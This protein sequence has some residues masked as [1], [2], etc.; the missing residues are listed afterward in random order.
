MLRW[1]TMDDLPKNRSKNRARLDRH[2][3]AEAKRGRRRREYSLTNKE[4][5]VVK[6]LIAKM[7]EDEN[8]NHA[9]YAEDGPMEM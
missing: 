2:R 3:K 9:L 6:R 5:E 4:D 8:G 1:S 7:R